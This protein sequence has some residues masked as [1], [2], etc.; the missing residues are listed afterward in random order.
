MCAAS[1]PRLPL[2]LA[3][4]PVRSEHVAKRLERQAML[5]EEGRQFVFLL[6]ERSLRWSPGPG[7][8]AVQRERLIAAAGRP[9]VTLGV[10]SDTAPVVGRSCST[11]SA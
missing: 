10:V 1:R 3:D 2:P 4:G 8:M 6:G 7:V 11:S 9:T 5:D